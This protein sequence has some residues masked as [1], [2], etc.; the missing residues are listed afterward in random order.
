[1]NNTGICS[2]RADVYWS[3]YLHLVDAKYD[4]YNENKHT[5]LIN[6][7]DEYDYWEGVQW[8]D[9]DDFVFNWV[10]GNGK[11]EG[12]VTY[13]TLT[14]EVSEDAANDA[15]LWVEAYVDGSDVFSDLDEYL[16]Y[17][18]INGGVDVLPDRGDVDGDYRIS[19]RDVIALFR[20]V[21]GIPA[22]LHVLSGDVNA[23]G[24]VNNKDVVELFRMSSSFSR[25]W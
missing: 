15:F 11:T 13:V 18:V 1:M 4:I 16:D 24:V 6:E 8:S 19:N 20:H 10:D 12:D 14:F 3:Q 2:L 21:S 22:Q 7:P 25:D 23:D 5:Q 17:T 9:L